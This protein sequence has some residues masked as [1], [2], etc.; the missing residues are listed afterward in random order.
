MADDTTNI[1]HFA[2]IMMF[3]PQW[4]STMFIDNIMIS[5]VFNF[6]F[7]I[8][9]MGILLRWKNSWVILGITC[10]FICAYLLLFF[11]LNILM[12]RNCGSA[13]I[14]F[15]NIF[16]LT[17]WKQLFSFRRKQLVEIE[18]QRFIEV[19]GLD[20]TYKGSTPVHA[21]RNVSLSIDK[22]D[23]TVLIGPNGSGKSTLLNAMTGS[24]SSDKG[25]LKIFGEKC[26]SGF[27]SLQQH[28]GICYQENILFERLNV[29]K[30]LEFFAT[31]RG[32]ENTKLKE[33]IDHSLSNFRLD[34]LENMKATTLSGGQ[35]RKL[36]TA[37]AF[38]GNPKLVILDE[39]TAGMD[40]S[41]RQEIWKAISCY[42]I[43]SIVS[44]HSIEEA[45]ILSSRMLVMR[46][47]ELIF[48]GISNELRSK[49]IDTR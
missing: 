35:K 9:N 18:G 1:L 36:C 31:I 7:T 33:V 10:G 20:K 49:F 14:G 24:I 39:P 4:M 3:L 26:V 44:T 30:H 46:N 23:V 34:G 48:E 8:K 21:L 5:K 6:P 42:N 15:S 25:D 32:V 2:S 17:A 41:I 27:S 11:L 43:T 13:P 19:I 45:G 29:Y 38:I 37:I 16:S 47:G 40:A 12:P 22:G 28:L